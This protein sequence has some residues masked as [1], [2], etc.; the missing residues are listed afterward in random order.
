MR[1]INEGM[2]L[3]DQATESKVNQMSQN[4]IVMPNYNNNLIK[5]NENMKLNTLSMTMRI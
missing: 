3:D 4:P 1:H 5:T 2:V